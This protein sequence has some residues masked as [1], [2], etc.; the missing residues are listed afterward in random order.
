MKEV[1]KMTKEELVSY[2]VE[3]EIGTEEV[4]SQMNVKDL[5]SE[6][7]IALEDDQADKEI[8]KRIADLEKEN[9][10]LKKKINGDADE[11]PKN[12]TTVS[13]VNGRFNSKVEP[14]KKEKSKKGK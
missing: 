12:Y 2:A 4:V 7:N 3:L 9:A 5:Q 10:N 14:E 6:I 11:G 8:Q 1:S 13:Q